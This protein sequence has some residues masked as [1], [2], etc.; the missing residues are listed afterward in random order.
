MKEIAFIV[1]FIGSL[2][3]AACEASTIGLQMVLMLVSLALMLV[4]VILGKEMEGS[5][6][7]D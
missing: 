3:L 5:D 4:A 1:C 2:M 6:K 7:R